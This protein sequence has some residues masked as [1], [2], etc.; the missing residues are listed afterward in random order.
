[1]DFGIKAAGP[2]GEGVTGS[3]RVDQCYVVAQ[4]SVTRRVAIPLSALQSIVADAVGHERPCGCIFA[5]AGRTY[6][7][8]DC[9][10]GAIKICACPACECITEF[11][12][13]CQ[14]ECGGLL[15]VNRRIW[16]RHGSSVEVV[17]DGRPV[18]PPGIECYHVAL[19]A[20]EVDNTLAV[21]VDDTAV[22]RQAPT[23]QSVAF[24]CK[25][26]GCQCLCGIVGEGLVGHRAGG[27]GGVLVEMDGIC[28]RCPLGVEG[29]CSP[30]V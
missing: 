9:H 6:R 17:A 8:G 10:G 7:D 19:V 4:D 14:R 22:R 30:L 2:A 21:E 5:F 24:A 16:C 18:E 26:I 29:N 11:G 23:C 25:G 15:G 12:W 28:Y 13:V 1:M 3:S 27:I 20:G